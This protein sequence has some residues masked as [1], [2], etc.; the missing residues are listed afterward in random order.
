[1][2]SK[3]F[4]DMDV[5]ARLVA[6]RPD[7]LDDGGRV[8][9]VTRARELAVAMR[10][11]VVV[12]G[13][14]KSRRPVRPRWG[15]AA[16]PVAAAVAVAVVQGGG[17]GSGAVTPGAEPAP[18]DSYLLAAAA[19]VE[20]T[21][22]QGATGD[23]W[24]QEERTGTLHQVPGDYVVDQRQMYR[25]WLAQ[26]EDRRWSQ[27]VDGG[28]GP[29]SAG[30]ERVWKEAGAPDLWTL[31]DD[32][33]TVRQQAQGVV[34]QDAPG[35]GAD[36]FPIGGLETDVLD[37]LPTDPEALRER[38]AEL[39]DSRFKPGDGVQDGEEEHGEQEGQDGQDG[40]DIQDWIVQQQII[41]IAVHLPADAELR[42]AAYRALA[43]EPG[44][45]DLGVVKD[46]SGREGRGVS[47]PLNG[48]RYE[49]RIVLDPA[50]GAPLGTLTA[51][52][53]AFDGWDKGAITAYTTTVEQS[54]TDVPPPF[55]DDLETSGPGASASR[56]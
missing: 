40:Q 36:V 56:D 35:G 11:D 4:D 46:R 26:G 21:G 7:A 51:T 28:T 55:D 25:Q 6:G 3:R 23:Y 15:L 52:T 30:D 22:E 53:R 24:Y 16:V 41:Q 5:M 8:D 37:E 39:T 49:L 31:P 17:G 29:A 19:K 2:G 33:G 14:R 13:P 9:P 34:Q 45:K 20:A 32:G 12:A 27:T 43:Q 54:W 50:T 42:A 44:V 1:M 48:G 18:A 38:L 47:V 10:P